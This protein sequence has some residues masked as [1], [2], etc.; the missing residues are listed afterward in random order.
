MG[1]RAKRRDGDGS[2]KRGHEGLDRHVYRKAPH[3]QA[4]AA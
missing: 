3:L 1:G 4:D 2:R